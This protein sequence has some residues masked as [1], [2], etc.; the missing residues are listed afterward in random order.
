MWVR[1]KGPRR[2]EQLSDLVTSTLLYRYVSEIPFGIKQMV[3]IKQ[4]VR[5]LKQ[6][7]RTRKDPEEQKRFAEKQIYVS[8]QVRTGDLQCVRLT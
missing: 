1:A 6:M 3:R 5:I 4:T 8:Y 2:S 7:V